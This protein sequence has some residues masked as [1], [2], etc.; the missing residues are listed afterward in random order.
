MVSVGG[1]L[2]LVIMIKACDDFKSLHRVRRLTNGP[3]GT[4]R[5]RTATHK[6]HGSARKHPA[7]HGNTQHD[8][9]THATPRHCTARH[10]TARHG[11]TQQRT[12]R[13]AT[14]RHHCTPRHGTPLHG[15]PLHGTPLHGTPTTA[16]HGTPRH[17]TAR[18]GNHCTA[19][20]CTARQP[21]HGT[22]T[23]ARH[24]YLRRQRKVGIRYALAG[25]VVRIG[26]GGGGLELCAA[27]L[28]V[29]WLVGVVGVVTVAAVPVRGGRGCGVLVVWRCGVVVLCDGILD[30]GVVGCWTVSRWGSGVVDRKSVV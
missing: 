12:P 30:D 17:A 24:P 4:P 7:R 16:R 23:T 21:L 22:A 18:H 1:R 15:T 29:E 26:D 19:R 10:R 6:G 13:H 25:G 5:Q 9:A 14:P 27:V 11:T 20:H 3:T 2:V 8:T 28:A